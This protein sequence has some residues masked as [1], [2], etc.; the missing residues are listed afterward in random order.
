MLTPGRLGTEED[1]PIP[2]TPRRSEE[3]ATA[4]A[5]RGVRSS[6]V[7]LAPSVHGPGD[8]GF[9]PTLIDIART[10][11]VSAYIGD[12]S[13]PDAAILYNRPNRKP[14]CSI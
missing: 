11:G 12:G 14:K 1:T 3:A 7:R 10:K 4:L 5:M 6:V 13:N 8:H 2:A 9:D